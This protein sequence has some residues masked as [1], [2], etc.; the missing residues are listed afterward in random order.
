MQSSLDSVS[1]NLLAMT[2]FWLAS[3]IAFDASAYVCPA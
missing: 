1:P 3:E 2:A